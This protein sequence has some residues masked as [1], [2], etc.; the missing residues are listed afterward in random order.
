MFA[1]TLTFL[2]G[3]VISAQAHMRSGH[4]E[5]LLG[6]LGGGAEGAK[7]GLSTKVVDLK[8]PS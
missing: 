7:N 8:F 1:A 2:L 4:V 3:G 5:A 6:A